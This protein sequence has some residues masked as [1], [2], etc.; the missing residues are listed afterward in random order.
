MAWGI[1]A[2]LSRR[3]QWVLKSNST[4]LTCLKLDQA[5]NTLCHLLLLLCVYILTLK[6]KPCIHFYSEN[7]SLPHK[8]DI[9][10][11]RNQECSLGSEQNC[12][13]MKPTSCPGRIPWKREQLAWFP[14][15]FLESR[16]SVCTCVYLWMWWKIYTC[17]SLSAYVQD[18]CRFF[19]CQKHASES[20]NL[21]SLISHTRLIIFP[22]WLNGEFPRGHFSPV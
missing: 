18:W 13:T 11:T 6:L 9:M 4:R 16:R 1:L 21:G 5:T 2:S 15:L 19:C 12:V 8:S 3:F 22:F 20:W 17:R 7:Q 14:M 10:R